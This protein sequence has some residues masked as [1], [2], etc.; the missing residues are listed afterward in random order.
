MMIKLKVE[1]P[2]VY[3]DCFFFQNWK[4][5]FFVVSVIAQI[6]SAMS[7]NALI[8]LPALIMI[9]LMAAVFSYRNYFEISYARFRMFFV[10][11]SALIAF[12]KMIMDSLLRI[13]YVQNEFF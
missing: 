1:L 8:D 2:L 5:A 9:L 3:F 7:F 10:Y 11:Y 12:I 13:K 6:I 4:A